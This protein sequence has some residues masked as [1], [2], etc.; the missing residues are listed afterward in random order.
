MRSDEIIK[1]QEEF[2][3]P[4][5]REGRYPLVLVEGKGAILKDMDGKEYIDCHGGYA[6]VTLGH[7]P[8]KVVEA[9]KRQAEK[10]WHVS[11]DFYL[12]STTL[13]AERLAE[14]CPG[15]LRRTLFSNSGAE[16]VE[17]A[18]KFA[19]KHASKQGREGTQVISLVGSFHGRTAYA[20]ALTGQNKYKKGLSTFVSP[21]VVHAP[22]PYCYRCPFSLTY[23]ECDLQC[24]KHLE[25][26]IKYQTSGDIAAFISEPIFGEGG[27]IVPP[28]PYLKEAVKIF[29]EHGA[30]YIADEVQTGF[31]KTGKLFGVGW[32]GVKP[33]VM[34]LAKGIASGLPLAATVATDEVAK[35]L[36]P[37]DHCATY[38]GN[39]VMCAAALENINVIV[40]ERLYEKAF[41]LGKAFME[42]LKELEEKYQ[43]IGEVRGKG[44]MIGVELVKDRKDKAPAKDECERIRRKAMKKG[45]LVNSGGVNSNVL[46]IQPPLAITEEQI[47]SVIETL[48]YAFGS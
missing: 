23:P 1:K 34:T 17:N 38:G 43:L 36:S 7:C 12:E 2:I 22:S 26:V 4:S 28:K 35:T 42:G 33:D 27:I 39:A 37:I 41:K 25:D 32:Y 11:W 31:A 3:L 46:R 6:A 44:L 29:K 8:P 14:I 20:M 16:A 5:T 13:L 15:K 10:I 48:D 9:V 19:K 47:K 24:A 30:L 45:A 18:V 40:K 21:N